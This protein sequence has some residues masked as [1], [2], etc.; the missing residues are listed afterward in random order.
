[1]GDSA[2][3]DEPSPG[4]L[5]RMQEVCALV[6]LSEESIRRAIKRGAFPAPLRIGERAI[7]FDERAIAKWISQRLRVR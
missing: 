1:M 7:A 2:K 6:A 3:R 5:L 4:R